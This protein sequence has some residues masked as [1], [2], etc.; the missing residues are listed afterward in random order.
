VTTLL[1]LVNP[2]GPDLLVRWDDG[3]DTTMKVP[4]GATACVDNADTFQMQLLS[5][6]TRQ[7][8]RHA[9]AEYA[10]FPYLWN[11]ACKMRNVSMG[12][13]SEVELAWEEL[14][15]Y[16]ERDVR[17][18]PLVWHNPITGEEALMVDAVCVRR[19]FSRT[20]RIVAVESCLH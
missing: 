17:T 20:R 16:E 19:F 12:L 14:P 6:S 15:A 2:V 3:T 13:P 7:L 5:P 8:V 18:Y 4:A 11:G 1:N 10:P 9:R